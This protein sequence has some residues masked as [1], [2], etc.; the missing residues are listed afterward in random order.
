MHAG[1]EGLY[2]RR[3]KKRN[4]PVRKEDEHNIVQKMRMMLE[5]GARRPRK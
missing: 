5:T 1:A 3:V 2:P 4:T